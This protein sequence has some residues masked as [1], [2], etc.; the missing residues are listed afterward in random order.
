MNNRE[1]CEEHGESQRQVNTEHEKQLQEEY[2]QEGRLLET[3]IEETK[4]ELIRQPIPQT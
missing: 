2:A 4:D 3:F 1:W